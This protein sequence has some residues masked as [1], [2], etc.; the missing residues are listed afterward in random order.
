MCLALLLTACASRPTLPAAEPQIVR[1]LPPTSLLADRA[2]PLPAGRRNQDLMQWAADLRCALRRS[3]A[4]KA[5]LRA[6]RRGEA[7]Q[8]DAERNRCND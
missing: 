6:W 4:D 5:A 8:G 1:E 2:E 3:N 7:Y